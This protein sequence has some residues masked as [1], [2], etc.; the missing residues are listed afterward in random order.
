MD[1]IDIDSIALDGRYSIRCRN[2]SNGYTR[3]ARS[4]L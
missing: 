2:Y 4:K 3:L 1:R